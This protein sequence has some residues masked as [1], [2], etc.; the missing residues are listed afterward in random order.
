MLSRWIEIGKLDFY[1]SL[2]DCENI[3]LKMEKLKVENKWKLI[4]YENI[5]T[6]Y[7]KDYN[8][9]TEEALYCDIFLEKLK[10]EPLYDKFNT[11]NF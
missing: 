8:L 2:L 5:K 11:M 1:V 6:S 7:I 3:N 9:D 4:I 10:I